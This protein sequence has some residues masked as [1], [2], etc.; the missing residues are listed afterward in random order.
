MHA[1][2]HTGVVAYYFQLGDEA[3]DVDRR[4]RLESL[5]SGAVLGLGD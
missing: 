2:K 4:A 3:V 5:T 1:R